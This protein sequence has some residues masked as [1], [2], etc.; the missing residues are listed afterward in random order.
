MTMTVHRGLPAAAVDQVRHRQH[1]L[2]DVARRMRVAVARPLFGEVEHRD[3]GLGVA[4][5]EGAMRARVRPA[6]SGLPGTLTV[7]GTALR[8]LDELGDVQL[9]GP[10][11]GTAPP[12]NA[13]PRRRASTRAWR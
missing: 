13:R 10:C 2:R 5:G 11:C 7:T 12:V 1:L 8:M 9:R 6:S 4:L 3:A